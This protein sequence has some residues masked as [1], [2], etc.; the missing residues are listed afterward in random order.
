MKL[1]LMVLISLNLIA[2]AKGS[3]AASAQKVIAGPKSEFEGSPE[4]EAIAQEVEYRIIKIHQYRSA[5]YRVSG[6]STAYYQIG[7]VFVGCKL[8]VVP[9]NAALFPGVGGLFDGNVYTPTEDCQ[10]IIDNE[11]VYNEFY[12][13]ASAH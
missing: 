7:N 10:F 6:G 13:M 5:L 11:Q 12:G 8:A 1:I 3:D 9:S 4:Q 2:C